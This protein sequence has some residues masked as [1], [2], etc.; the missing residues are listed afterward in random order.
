MADADKMVTVGDIM[1]PDVPTVSPGASVAAVARVLADLGIP[2]VPVVDG[3][4][5]VGIVT[6]ADLIAR[7]AEVSVPTIVP[8]LDAIFVADAGEPFDEELRRVLAL[9]AGDLMTSPV[10]NI[11]ASASL[12]QLATLMIEQRVNPVPVVD[13]ELTLVGLVSRVDLVKVIARLES[14]EEPP[15]PVGP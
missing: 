10:Y 12:T 2:G 13:E 4:E 9:T 5:L 1:Q 6:E 15:A 3:D 14:A 7:Q 11:R 8:F